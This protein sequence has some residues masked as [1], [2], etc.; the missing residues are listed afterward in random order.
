MKRKNQRKITA[1]ELFSEIYVMQ[2]SRR[3]TIAAA[4]VRIRFGSCRSDPAQSSHTYISL[5]SSKMIRRRIGVIKNKLMKI[6]SFPIWGE[7]S[8]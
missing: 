2:V 3:I 6:T 1:H 4:R 7:Q 5:I 8:F